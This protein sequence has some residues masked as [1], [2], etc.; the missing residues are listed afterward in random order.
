M[1]IKV[2]DCR[3]YPLKGGAAVS[4][5]E[6]SLTPLG[7]MHDRRWMLVHD[8]GDKRGK[9]IS[10]RGPGLGKLALVKALPEDANKTLFSFP[11]RPE[12]SVESTH[13]KLL[14]YPV[15][16]WG[17]ECAA[18]DAGDEVAELFSEYLAVPCRLVKMDEATPRPT[19]ADYSQPGD[20]VSF[21]DGMPLL[22]ANQ[23]SLDALNEA[24]DVAPVGM[25]RFRANIVLEGAAAFEEDV[26][27]EA[28]IGETVLE[29]TL[30]CARCGV[31]NINQ[32]T[33]IAESDEPSK[34][35]IATRRGESGDLRGVFFGQNAI[36]RQLGR[37]RVGDT[38][39]IL[40]RRAM[41]SV[42]DKAR[43]RYRETV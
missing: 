16:V 35:L 30:P 39:E 14:D 37:I 43:L 29:F 1:S 34:T 28:R 15:T 11:G 7:P 32:A 10:Q 6:V 23:A 41:H 22:V 26:I 13:L 2:I 36:P 18:F 9:F 31:P 12:I 24:M 5:P 40:S 38:V 19:H 27:H 17:S 8:A 25:D 42:L 4:L 21:A 33:G 3:V 20:R